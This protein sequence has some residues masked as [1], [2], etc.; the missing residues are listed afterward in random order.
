[1]TDL[2]LLYL[3][4]FAVGIV[5]IGRVTR[6]I[7]QDHYPPVVWLRGWLAARLP[8]SWALVLECPFCIA[9]YVAALDTWW[10]VGSEVSGWWLIVNVWVAS[11]YLAAILVLRDEP[12]EE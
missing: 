1:M 7:T 3:A 2:T 5:A 6:F 12:P 8:E 9:P 11:S 4:A 10:A